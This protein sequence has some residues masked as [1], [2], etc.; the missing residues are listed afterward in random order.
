MPR[1][2]NVELKPLEERKAQEEHAE[3]LRNWYADK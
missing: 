2:I 3:R 1:R